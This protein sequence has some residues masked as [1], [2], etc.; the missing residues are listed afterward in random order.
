MACPII[1]DSGNYGKQKRGI[2]V[3]L[4]SEL[5]DMKVEDTATYS[6]SALVV[7]YGVENE[8]NTK[9]IPSPPPT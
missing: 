7:L 2:E 6:I 1:H 9:S 4:A 3:Q 8:N 5:V